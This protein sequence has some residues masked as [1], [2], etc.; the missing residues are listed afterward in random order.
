MSQPSA[1]PVS[2][3]QSMVCMTQASTTCDAC[4]A[5]LLEIETQCDCGTSSARPTYALGCHRFGLLWCAES[6]QVHVLGTKNLRSSMDNDPPP[7]SDH[8]RTA[9]SPSRRHKDR[10][11]RGRHA[12]RRRVHSRRALPSLSNAPLPRNSATEPT[13]HAIPMF[14]F[15]NGRKLT[16][17]DVN[18]WLQRYT[19]TGY[20]SHSLRIGKTTCVAHRCGKFKQA[21][22]GLAARTSGTSGQR[23]QL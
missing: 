15:A 8:S 6:V 17:A 16:T 3:Q 5:T 4:P 18:R 7:H 20:T 9:D 21:T 19:G 2:Q 12:G 14:R 22:V 23:R 13:R 1:D 11:S 10:P